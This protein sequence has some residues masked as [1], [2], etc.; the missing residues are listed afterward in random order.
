MVG[1][2]PSPVG[3]G[4]F[5]VEPD[6]RLPGCPSGEERRLP[7]QPALGLVIGELDDGQFRQTESR[8][9]EVVR[10]GH[11]GRCPCQLA[12]QGQQ[13]APV[14]RVEPIQQRISR[15]IVDWRESTGRDRSG[16]GGSGAERDQRAVNVQKHDRI[17]SRAGHHRQNL[18]AGRRI[19]IRGRAYAI[20]T[21]GHRRWGR[22]R[23]IVAV[24]TFP[25]QILASAV[26]ERDETWERLNMSRRAFPIQPNHGK[27]FVRVELESRAWL[28]QIMIWSSGEA[29]LETIRLTDDRIVNK[30]YDLT[31]RDDLNVLLNELVRLLVQDEAPD[32]AVVFYAPGSRRDKETRRPR[33]SS[34]GDVNPTAAT[35]PQPRAQLIR[36]E[37]NHQH[38]R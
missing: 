16:L 8:R 4:D 15:R 9:D 22:G 23:A 38:E 3:V 29:E 24:V 10:V 17:V 37:I 32:A 34:D 36:D 33:V 26:E 35:G 28:V 5:V 19:T 12:S 31:N 13:L 20:G 18:P 27:P 2:N 14:R 30:H 25:L 11:P 6:E 1:L 21:R 7:V